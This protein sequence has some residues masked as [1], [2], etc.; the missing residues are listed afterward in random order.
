MSDQFYTFAE[1]LAADSFDAIPDS[2]AETIKVLE[3]YGVS[4]SK[5]GKSEAAVAARADLLAGIVWLHINHTTL[6]TDL[7][8]ASPDQQRLLAAALGLNYDELSALPSWPVVL[9]RRL[10]HKLLPG[11]TPVKR[12]RPDASSGGGP[13]VKP[14]AAPQPQGGGPVDADASAAPPPDAPDKRRRTSTSTPAH[15]SSSSS[16]SS[17]SSDDEGFLAG[18]SAALAAFPLAPMPPELSYDASLRQ[19][20]TARCGR[21]WLPA[22]K[23]E[24]AIPPRYRGFLVRTKTWTPKALATYDKMV[25]KARAGTGIFREDRTCPAYVHRLE[26]EFVNDDTLISDGALLALACACERPSDFSG[27]PGIALGGMRGRDDY[28]SVIK[29][30]SAGWT[31]LLAAGAQ[32]RS[33]G[34]ATMFNIFTGL[35]AVQERR[36]ARLAK[37]LLACKGRE[38]ILAHTARQ[39]FQT[40]DYLQNLQHDIAGR[41]GGLDL[42]AQAAFECHR[43]ISFLKPTMDAVLHADTTELQGSL[44]AAA[45]ASV[46][47]PSAAPAAKRSILKA[48]S[49]VSFGPDVADTAPAPAAVTPAPVAP[50]P[51]LPYGSWP[52]FAPFY[53]PPAVP[54]P[55][56]GLWPGYSGPLGSYSSPVAA[57]PPPGAGSA[58]APSLAGAAASPAGVAGRGGGVR[59]DRPARRVSILTGKAKARAD[60]GL[61]FSGQPQH[62]WVTGE[63][64]ASAPL[65]SC[66]T[67]V[68]GCANSCGVPN[69][70]LHATWDCPLRY[71]K[72]FQRCPGFL[73]SGARDPAQWTGDRLT[74]AAKDAWLALIAEEELP[75]PADLG[76]RPPPF[77]S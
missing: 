6:N 46:V 43:Y 33:P 66:W 30:L 20:I 45:T 58:S 25:E 41:A 13:I 38:E 62:A 11:N 10:L 61:P 31:T 22:D 48:P 77:H 40:Q 16:H 54:A 28:L 15:H 5:R 14:G 36:Y 76:A 67:P 19:L 68:C 71:W 70:G 75:L 29:I 1:L 52:P 56:S 8:R 63:D 37:V 17:D 44:L 21:P 9:E 47:V 53:G 74:R 3:S 59:A 24:R 51:A 23:L 60:A 27:A 39:Y 50:P 2:D 12:P 73:P 42:D 57:T 64:C 65:N 49:T 72:S 4:F 69:I 34:A 26:F 32:G 55:P 35:Q 18:G 7:A